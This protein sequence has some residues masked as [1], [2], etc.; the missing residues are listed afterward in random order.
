MTNCVRVS[1]VLLQTN[2]GDGPTDPT[3]AR[4]RVIDFA[5]DLDDVAPDG[6]S[7]WVERADNAGVRDDGWRSIQAAVNTLRRL[8]FK[9]MSVVL[10]L[11]VQATGSVLALSYTEVGIYQRS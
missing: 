1:A 7:G 8:G 10:P 3:C 4:V 6:T 5:S 11:P 2:G 9:I